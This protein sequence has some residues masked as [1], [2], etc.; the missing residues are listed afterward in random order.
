MAR[1]IIDHETFVA[2][3]EAGHAV[4]CVKLRV[5]FSSV[6]IGRGSSG[7]GAG[8]DIE[9]FAL[10]EADAGCFDPVELKTYA[11][12]CRKLVIVCLAG[13]TAE[14]HADRAALTYGAGIGSDLKDLRDARY[15]VGQLLRAES[16]LFSARG[17][18][19]L[20]DQQSIEALPALL[21]AE[22]EK[23]Q[24]EAQSLVA[25]HFQCICHVA[26]ELVSQKYLSAV[27]VERVV[28]DFEP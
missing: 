8:V 18:E 28:G 12:R 5:P 20:V 16:L 21:V 11:E 24:E 15:F 14:E 27:E 6:S 4:A 13:R 1:A 19:S 17:Q 10:E 7:F 9:P 23:L 22:I 2:I 26:Q 3:H 25:A